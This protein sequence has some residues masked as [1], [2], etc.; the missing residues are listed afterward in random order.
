M[1]SLGMSLDSK[2]ASDRQLCLAATVN[3]MDTD[4]VPDRQSEKQTQPNMP[5]T[6]FLACIVAQYISRS[7]GGEIKIGMQRLLDHN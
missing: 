6:D 5:Q 1:G 7:A 3:D 4:A 2:Q